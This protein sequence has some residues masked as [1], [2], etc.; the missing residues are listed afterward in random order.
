MAP[1][2]ESPIDHQVIH[3]IIVIFPFLIL[4][5]V[6]FVGLIYI[7]CEYLCKVCYAVDSITTP[8]P[9]PSPL[10]YIRKK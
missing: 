6:G 1:I 3:L 9:P 7:S 5:S 2:N 10:S 4:I 8:P